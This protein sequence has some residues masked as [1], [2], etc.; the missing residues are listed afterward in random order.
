VSYILVSNDQDQQNAQRRVT[1][2]NSTHL[3]DRQ[4]E[5][6]HHVVEYD[7]MHMDTKYETNFDK[8]MQQTALIDEK[9]ETHLEEV[10]NDD[11]E[12]V[13]TNMDNAEMLADSTHQQGMNEAYPKKAAVSRTTTDVDPQ[14]DNAQCRLIHGNSIPREF[15]INKALPEVFVNQIG[16]VISLN[17][18]TSAIIRM[19]VKD[20]TKRGIEFLHIIDDVPRQ[21]G[22]VAIARRPS[23]PN[24]ASKKEEP[25]VQ[26]IRCQE[27]MR[28]KKT[29]MH[30][31][32][33]PETMDD[34]GMHADNTCQQAMYE[35]YRGEDI[36][37]TCLVKTAMPRNITNDGPPNNNKLSQTGTVDAAKGPSVPDT[38]SEKGEHDV[39]ETSCHKGVPDVPG[40]ATSNNFNAN[41]PKDGQTSYMTS[42]KEPEK[43]A[44]TAFTSGEGHEVTISPMA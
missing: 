32:K 20:K 25:N 29:C 5:L 38:A 31:I 27:D 1:T 17:G 8:A 28:D 14:N 19:D 18:S 42:K 6:T 15:F 44:M 24:A 4:H 2:A 13:D 43:I 22:T 37:K 11:T 23:V 3:Q 21:T 12:S 41:S 7:A 16:D 33:V 9:Y 35:T 10:K 36:D 30:I 26:E 40:T 34:A 39:K